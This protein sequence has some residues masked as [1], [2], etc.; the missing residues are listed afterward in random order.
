MPYAHPSLEG[1]LNDS[2]CT[3]VLLHMSEAG[4]VWPSEHPG[5]FEG[6]CYLSWALSPGFILTS[7][8]ER[9][10]IKVSLRTDTT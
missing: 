5:V 9:S 1:R 7:F 2:V 6:E 4:V 3:S 10:I 8:A